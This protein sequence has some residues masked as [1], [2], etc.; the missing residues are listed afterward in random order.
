MIPPLGIYQD[1]RFNSLKPSAQRMKFMTSVNC[2]C[3]KITG[4]FEEKFMASMTV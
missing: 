1:K 3:Y 2:D 4:V